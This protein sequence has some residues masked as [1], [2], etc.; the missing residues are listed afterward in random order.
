MNTSKCRRICLAAALALMAVAIGLSPCQ[1]TTYYVKAGLGASDSN[2]GTSPLN[3][4]LTPQHAADVAQAG[5]TVLFMT[6]TYRNPT[7]NGTVMD[8]TH[9]GKPDAPIV[10]SVMAGE[11]PVFRSGGWS[12]IHIHGGAS[13]IEIKGLTLTGMSATLSLP[14]AKK[15]EKDGQYARMNTN[16]IMVDGRQ[17]GANKPHHITIDGNTVTMFPGGGIATCQ[18]DYITVTDNN[19]DDNA[20]YSVYGCSGISLYQCWNYD[21]ATGYHNRVERNWC[22]GNKN[23]IPTMA[24]GTFTD[25]NGIILDDSKNTQ[26][27]STIGPYKGR[28]LIANNFCYENGGS[29]IHAFSSEHADIIYNTCIDNNMTPEL[30]DGQ[31]FPNA[32]GD[33]RF[34]NNILVG[35]ALKPINSNW[36][37]GAVTWDYNI[38]WGGKAAIKG[39]HDITA[40]PQVS[41]TRIGQGIRLLISPRSPAIDKADPSLPIS[42]DIYKSSRP[43]GKG[44]DIGCLEAG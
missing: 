13:Y 5:D 12:A 40:D 22:V 34:E 20:W 33:V 23:E 29:G 2:S 21:D 32:S 28:T 19:V 43:K 26:G 6:G 36:N 24:T 39:P 38:L 4:F 27:G 16:G 14:E 3:A 9:S 44:C 42:D 31:I 37:N 35:P 18:A 1:A 25:G 30:K 8:I 10:F 17:D 15:R 7:T 41:I 11:H